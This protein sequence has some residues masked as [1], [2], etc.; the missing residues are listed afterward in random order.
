MNSKVKKHT[1]KTLDTAVQSI[2]SMTSAETFLM[3]QKTI[4][5]AKTKGTKQ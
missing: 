5:G 1:K 3:Q 4:L 2:F